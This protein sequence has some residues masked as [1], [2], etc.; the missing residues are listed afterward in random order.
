MTDMNLGDAGDE[1]DTTEADFDAMW[2]EGT[3]VQ[4]VRSDQRIKTAFGTLF[5]SFGPT[6]SENARR[7][8]G[9]QIH[10]FG[11]AVREATYA[12]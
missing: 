1:A 9:P 5:I 6:T 8:P 12:P 11:G 2:K 7:G 10:T 3:P 4:V